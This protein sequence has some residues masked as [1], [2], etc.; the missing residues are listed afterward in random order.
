M[1]RIFLL[2]FLIAYVGCSASIG[3]GL[4]EK[5][6][7]V[8]FADNME[9]IIDGETS[10]LP[11]KPK[12]INGRM[13][14]PIEIFNRIPGANY[15]YENEDKSSAK[16]SLDIPRMYFDGGEYSELINLIRNAK[17][18]IY[19]QIY[20]MREWG[21]IEE[22]AKAGNRKIDIKVIMD[23]DQENTVYGKNGRQEY[24][25]ETNFPTSEVRWDTRKNL[26][27]RK[28]AVFDK[29]TVFIGSTNWSYT[30][31]DPDRKGGNREDGMI[32]KNEVLAKAITEKF[33]D[34]WDRA[35]QDYNPSAEDK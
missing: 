22:I 20:R 15:I 4:P 9:T 35:S 8:V 31:L 32:Y 18:S 14:L 19:I 13:Y 30:G 26:M 12:I 28:L 6:T 3:V 2:A 16:I 34:D 24:E 1:R 33:F 29:E 10:N 25:I 21:I 5:R 11:D 7:I 27:H 23:N 17:K